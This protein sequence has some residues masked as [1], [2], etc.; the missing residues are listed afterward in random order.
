M[1]CHPTREAGL[2]QTDPVPDAEHL[3][4]DAPG[5]EPSLDH[6]VHASTDLAAAVRRFEQ[7]TGVPPV[8]GGRH[9]GLGTRNFLVGL[10]AGPDRHSYLELIGPDPEQPE[11]AQP[12]PFGVDRLTRPRLVTWA[13]RPADLDAAAERARRLGHEPGPVR[14]MSRRTPFGALLQWRLTEP[15]DGLVPFLIDWQGSPHPSRSGL[16]TLTL[17][18][19]FGRHPEPARVGS[20]LAALGVRLRVEPGEPAELVARLRGPAGEVELR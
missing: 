4:P 9:L 18:E 3:E 7:L 6:L 2:G 8:E 10:D 17:I 12:R 16:P 19:L 5:V 1:R 15:G 20:A 14:A 11:P 13:V